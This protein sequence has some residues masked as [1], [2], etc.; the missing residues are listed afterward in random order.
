MRSV[1]FASG[2]ILVALGVVGA[3]LPV[4]PTTIFLILAAGCFGKSSPRMERWIC[5]HPRLGPPVVAWQQER[6]IR[7]RHK[8]FAIVL[9]WI[10]ILSSV[11]FADLALPLDGMLLVIAVSLTVFL[12]TRPTKVDQPSAFVRGANVR[13][14]ANELRSSK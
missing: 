13:G 12:L 3:F 4:M 11:A 10:S 2:V 14:P 7:M 1:Y 8:V 9:I 5:E 6:S